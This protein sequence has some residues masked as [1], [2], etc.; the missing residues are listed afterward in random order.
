MKLCI[1]WFLQIS[2]FHNVM[3]KGNLEFS[4]LFKLYDS[5]CFELSIWCLAVNGYPKSCQGESKY[6]DHLF[7]IYF[8]WLGYC[9]LIYLQRKFNFFFDG[10]PF[11]ENYYVRSEVL[12]MRVEL[13]DGSYCDFPTTW[14]HMGPT[15]TQINVIFRLMCKQLE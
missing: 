4:I 12:H 1:A 5:S 11:E 7:N 14:D 3:R 13:F 9:I 15:N 8:S 2:I 6:Y 10:F